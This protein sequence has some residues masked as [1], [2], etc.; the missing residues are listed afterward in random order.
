M[1]Q[2]ERVGNEPKTAVGRNTQGK[3]QG[4]KYFDWL[5]PPSPHFFHLTKPLILNMHF[6]FPFHTFLPKNIFLVHFLKIS[7]NKNK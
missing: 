5:V 2:A 1:I 3:C 4:G 6:I 7:C